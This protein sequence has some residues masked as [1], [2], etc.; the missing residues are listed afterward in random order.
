MSTPRSTGC[1]SVVTGGFVQDLDN[2]RDETVARLVWNRSNLAGWSVE[3]GIEGV[4]NKLDSDVNVFRIDGAGAQTRIDL[5]VD[6][7]VVKEY[8]GE[9]F[10]NAGKAALQDAP[11][12]PRP[13][14]R[15]VAADGARRRRRRS[16]C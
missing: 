8:R 7:A 14:L 10:V 6:Q 3:T 15:G 9:A 12:R 5:P 2:Q 11:A 13:H 1:S 16:G 4:V